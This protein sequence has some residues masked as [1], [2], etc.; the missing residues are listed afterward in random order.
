MIDQSFI[1][2]DV[3]DRTFRNKIWGLLIDM[4]G[5][6]IVSAP[7]KAPEVTTKSLSCWLTLSDPLVEELIIP[8]LIT[9]GHDLLI[10]NLFRSDRLDKHETDKFVP[11]LKRV[12]AGGRVVSDV[13]GSFT[14]A[15][16]SSERNRSIAGSILEKVGAVTVQV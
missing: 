5:R 13:A 16:L 1:R 3:T 8:P 7:D 15:L 14:V 6:A 10:V 4:S 11:S 2:S 9:A 12:M